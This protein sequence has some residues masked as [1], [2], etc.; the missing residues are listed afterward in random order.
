MTIELI[1]FRFS[2]GGVMRLLLNCNP[3]IIDPP[4]N[5]GPAVFGK[6]FSIRAKKVLDY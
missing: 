2:L 4:L 1:H 5:Q 3:D 6:I